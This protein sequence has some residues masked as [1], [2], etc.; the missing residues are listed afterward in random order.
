M[1]FTLTVSLTILTAYLIGAFLPWWTIFPIIALIYFFIP[2]KPW[3]SFLSGFSA[4]FLLWGF[5]ALYMDTLNK[6]LLSKK[7]S[8]IVFQNEKYGYLI[9]LTAFIGALSGGLS[10]L[11]GALAKR[12]FD[13]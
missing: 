12:I 11:T 8:M 6:H 5:L 10:A 7:I 2:M 13:N 9:L 1:K 3:T 4:L